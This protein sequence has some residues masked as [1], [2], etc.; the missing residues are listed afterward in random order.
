MEMESKHI[1]QICGMIIFL[2]VFLIVSITLFYV[3]K[4]RQIAKIICE[5]EGVDPIG[6]YMALTDPYES[7]MTLYLLAK[8]KEQPINSPNK[9]K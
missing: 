3:H 7:K 8:D 2:I 1:T 4:D 9:S 6:A 5:C